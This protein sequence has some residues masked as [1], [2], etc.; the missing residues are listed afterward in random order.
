VTAPLPWLD[1]VLAS[2]LVLCAAVGLRRGL[3]PELVAL[4]GWLV[5]YFAAG[6]AAPQVAAALPVGTPG[7]PLNHAVALVLAF[8]GGVALWWLV[9]RVLPLLL[10]RRPPSGPERALAAV[11]GAF[12]GL[13]LLLALATAVSLTPAAQSD[14]WQGSWIAHGVGKM[15]QGLRPLLPGTLVQAL[16]A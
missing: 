10:R 7:G 15:V 6:W 16:P 4:A 3:V 9:S 11:F 8:L 5:A 1:A 2:A 13:V 14:A 12:R